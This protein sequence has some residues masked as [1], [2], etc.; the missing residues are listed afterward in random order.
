MDCVVGCSSC[1]YLDDEALGVDHPD[2]L[3]GVGWGHALF[4]HGHDEQVGDTQSRLGQRTEEEEE[5]RT[6]YNLAATC[7]LFESL[8]PIVSC[9]EQSREVNSRHH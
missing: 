6:L 3:G 2:L 8:S 7:S 5:H 1:G 9:K 4:S